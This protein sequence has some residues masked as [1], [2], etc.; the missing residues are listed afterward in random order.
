MLKTLNYGTIRL[1]EAMEICRP[2]DT[3][4]DE[5]ELCDGWALIYQL[6]EGEIVG[7]AYFD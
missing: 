3:Q 7:V 4:I 6:A 1:V 5:I 2:F